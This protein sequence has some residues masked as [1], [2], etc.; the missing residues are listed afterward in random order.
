MDAKGYYQDK[1]CIVTGAN[2][3]IGYALSE[4]LL[5]R[6]ATVYMAGRDPKKVATA[7]GQLTIYKDRVRTL[8]VDVVNQQQVQKAVDDTAAEAGRLDMLFNNAGVG[9]SGPFEKGTLDDW[10]AII[11]TDLW[12]VIYGV[13]A[14]VP[15]MIRQGSG[16]IVNTSSMGGLTPVPFQSLYNTTKYAV[17]GLTESLRY[18]YAEK[19]ISFSALCPSF[20]ASAIFNKGLDGS[21]GN[22]KVPE[23]AYPADKAA[24]YCLDKVAE[25]KGII[26]VPEEPYTTLWK[27]YTIGEPATEKFMSMMAQM[28]R[29]EIERGESPTAIPP[30]SMLE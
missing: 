1:I 5:K 7:A 25:Q 22:Q 21:V 17:T 23:G 2:S 26:V 24:S 16:H 30:L 11:D 3:G 28:R 20:I 15:I 13:H 12:S 9:H 6:G 8:I 14:A 27:R 18:E 10:K 19:G 29:K 4:E